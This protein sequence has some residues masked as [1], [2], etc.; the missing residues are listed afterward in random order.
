MS[1]QEKIDNEV[2]E[3]DKLIGEALESLQWC[4]GYDEASEVL[5]GIYQRLMNIKI[6]NKQSDS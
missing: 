5:N 1:K 2:V 3:A 4:D 6:I